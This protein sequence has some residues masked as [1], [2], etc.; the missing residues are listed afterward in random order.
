MRS[1]VSSVTRYFEIFVAQIGDFTPK[2]SPKLLKCQN[3]YIK[4][5]FKPKNIYIKANLKPQNIYIKG[6][7]KASYVV[8]K[9]KILPSQ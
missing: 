8:K 9:S 1:R 3:I 7:F 4:A 6:G 2:M 5:F